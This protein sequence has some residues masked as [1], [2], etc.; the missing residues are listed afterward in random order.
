M[1]NTCL[2]EHISSLPSCT[3]EQ[4]FHFR[5]ALLPVLFYSKVLMAVA[6]IW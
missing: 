6:T 2:Q 4:G 1:Y 3:T 5:S